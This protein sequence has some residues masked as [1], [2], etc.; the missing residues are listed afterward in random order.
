[1]IIVTYC[2]YLCLFGYG[3]LLIIFLLF[4][5]GAHI[6]SENDD[7]EQIEYLRKYNER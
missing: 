2:L 3:I 4:N 5:H 7:K 1:M 6:N